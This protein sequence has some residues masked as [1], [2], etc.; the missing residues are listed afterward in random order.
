MVQLIPESSYPFFGIVFALVPG[1]CGVLLGVF[2]WILFLCF[3]FLLL[4]I[5]FPGSYGI[6]FAS[7]TLGVGALCFM[8]GIIF[9]PY[10]L[11]L[12]L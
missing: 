8:D 2:C 1:L 10:E 3:S 7:I 11:I 9:G 5:H 12:C 4:G 6:M